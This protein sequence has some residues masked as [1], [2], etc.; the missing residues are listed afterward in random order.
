MGFTLAITRFN[1]DIKP[2]LIPQHCQPVFFSMLCDPYDT[3]IFKTKVLH[4]VSNV[5][6]VECLLLLY[7][8]LIQSSLAVTVDVFY[9]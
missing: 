5:Q 8:Q 4:L 2:Q 6:L 3:H 1:S 7:Q 9:N